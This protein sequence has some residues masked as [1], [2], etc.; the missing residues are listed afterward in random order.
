MHRLA[1]DVTLRLDP[2]QGVPSLAALN[3]IR[4]RSEFGTNSSILLALHFVERDPLVHT[5]CKL[6]LAAA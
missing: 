6:V 2:S 1:H 3:L 4:Q 5:N